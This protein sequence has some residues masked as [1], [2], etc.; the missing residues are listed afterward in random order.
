MIIAKFGVSDGSVA[1]RSFLLAAVMFGDGVGR[2]R[3][4]HA[5]SASARR[6]CPAARRD[7]QLAGLITSAVRLPTV[8]SL[9]FRSPGFNVRSADD[10]L[11]RRPPLSSIQLAGAAI[12]PL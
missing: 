12:R 11:S 2:A 6:R 5:G 9:Q 7:G 1:M 4:R 10:L 8:R 3:G